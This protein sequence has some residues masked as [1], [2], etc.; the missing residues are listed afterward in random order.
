MSAAGAWRAVQAGHP[1]EVLVRGGSE[2]RQQRA[3]NER[4]DQAAGQQGQHDAVPGER[5]VQ[6]EP[7]LAAALRAQLPVVRLHVTVKIP[8]IIGDLD[9]D[10]WQA[11][12]VPFRFA[13]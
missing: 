8:R 6:P 9:V 13:A 2:D 5:A 11:S 12:V 1:G 7:A 10:R 3:G 4:Q